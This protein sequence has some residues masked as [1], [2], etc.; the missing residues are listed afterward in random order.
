VQPIVTGLPLAADVMAGD[1]PGMVPLAKAIA[2]VTVTLTVPLEVSMAAS[3]T[4]IVLSL[5]CAAPY[6]SEI[7]ITPSEASF[8]PDSTGPAEFVITASAPTDDIARCDRLACTWTRI[9]GSVAMPANFNFFVGTAVQL[10]VQQV[11][12]QTD[13]AFFPF[14]PVGHVA[15]FYIQ[16]AEGMIAKLGSSVA[17][18]VSRRACALEEHP[19]GTRRIFEA[20]GSPVPAVC[21]ARGGGLR[22]RSRGG[23]VSLEARPEQHVGQRF[24]RARARRS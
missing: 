13:T 3:S 5:S 21:F 1:V 2:G 9:S 23:H 20:G 12:S 6:N 16:S 17:I 11:A 15:H 24:D 19:G 4:P 7:T 8:N 18:S 22:G 10:E 14:V